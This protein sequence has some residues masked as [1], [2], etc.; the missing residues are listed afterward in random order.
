MPDNII[1]FSEEQRKELLMLLPDIYMTARNQNQENSSVISY[2]HEQIKAIKP[3]IT[4]MKVDYYYT[5]LQNF[6]TVTLTNAE[7][8]LIVFNGYACKGFTFNNP[9]KNKD[10][11]YNLDF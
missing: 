2:F 11:F 1:L 9:H 6:F 4:I 3:S 10:G 5:E 7:D 8:S